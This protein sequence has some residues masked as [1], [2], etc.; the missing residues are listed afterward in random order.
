MVVWAEDVYQECVYRHEESNVTQLLS[1]SSQAV[2]PPQGFGINLS[3]RSGDLQRQ[4]TDL[5]FVEP[6]DRPHP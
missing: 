6:T 2:V 5:L 4:K 3:S 1:G